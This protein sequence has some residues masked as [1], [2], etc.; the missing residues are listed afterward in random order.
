MSKALD[1]ERWPVNVRSRIAALNGLMGALCES[2][3][4]DCRDLR[5]AA[6]IARSAL[7][8]SPVDAVMAEACALD[9]ATLV[10]YPLDDPDD[11]LQACG[12]IAE[13]N[14]SAGPWES[15]DGDRE[16]L[17]QIVAV[18]IA[19]VLACDAAAKGGA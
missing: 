3:A 10:S 18:A 13:G 6:E 15:E 16:R 9:V 12:D 19:G 1:L 2:L 8:P 7:A 14:S 4:D 11:H 17:V 5:L